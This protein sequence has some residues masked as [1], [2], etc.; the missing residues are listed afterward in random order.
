MECVD[1][2]AEN[3]DLA[4][5]PNELDLFDDSVMA[6]WIGD[7]IQAVKKRKAMSYVTS[8]FRNKLTSESRGF[9]PKSTGIKGQ[10]RW[11]RKKR[12][13]WKRNGNRSRR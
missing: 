9:M 13:R 2:S 3:F 12:N 4:D 11:K 7:E 10:N 8:R 1:K 5:I 6:D